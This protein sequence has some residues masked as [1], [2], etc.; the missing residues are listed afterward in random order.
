MK[1]VVIQFVQLEFGM[2]GVWSTNKICQWT[3]KWTE[4]GI[5]EI[6]LHST[7]KEEIHYT[8]FHSACLETRDSRLEFLALR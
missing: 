4:Y 7:Y 8:F 6:Y 2:Y 5:M 1:K 3:R